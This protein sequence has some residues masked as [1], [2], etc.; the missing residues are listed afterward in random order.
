MLFCY[1]F[2]NFI[3]VGF[4][5]QIVV[6]NFVF[7]LAIIFLN[8]DRI[9]ERVKLIVATPFLSTIAIGAFYLI[10]APFG[11]VADRGQ[12]VSVSELPSHVINVTG[13][14]FNLM[15]NTQ[16]DIN[17]S[18]FFRGL[19]LINTVGNILTIVFVVV[20]TIIIFMGLMRR[21]LD[22]EQSHFDER[23]I[24]LLIIGMILAIA[25]FAPFYILQNSFMAPRTIYPAIFGIA[26]FFD[27]ILRFVSSRF[28]V[29]IKAVV[30]TVLIIPFFIIYIAEV[31][32]YKLLEEV[33][34]KIMANFLEVFAESGLDE[35][36]TI[37]LFN[38]LYTY[39][40]VTIAGGP[41][42]LENITSSDWALIGMANAVSTEFYFRQMVPIQNERLVRTDW[43]DN[44]NG[45][46]GIDENLNI[47]R[48]RLVGNVLYIEEDSRSFGILEEYDEDMSRFRRG[49][50]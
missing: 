44:E 4:Y 14:I 28:S 1:I 46:F 49:R 13:R 38:T 3:A 25:P 21:Q 11:K 40:D 41:H 43:V 31:N 18:G 24:T 19:T 10:L 42:R 33:D 8:F 29:T 50:N 15:I 48:L 34:Q 7:T 30:S 35:E 36:V 16:Q 2:F 45:L 23:Y 12:L 22:I 27:T 17:I 47:F 6:F 39:A 5:E 26:I 9:T 37:L 32:N 20:C